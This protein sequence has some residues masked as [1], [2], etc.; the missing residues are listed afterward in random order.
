MTRE[1]MGIRL[2]S[3]LKMAD[4][5]PTEE[6]IQARIRRQARARREFLIAENDRI[7]SY[8]G[9]AVDRRA[10]EFVRREERLRQRKREEEERKKRRECAHITLIRVGI[11]RAARRKIMEQLD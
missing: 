10:E 8:S 6:E 3:W 1:K 7:N 9:R 11:P 5:D 2:A 4:Q